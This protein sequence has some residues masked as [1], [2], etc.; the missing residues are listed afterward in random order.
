MKVRC[1][2][3]DFYNNYLTEGKVYEGEL[4]FDERN[5]ENRW[6][7]K[8]LSM[9]AFKEYRF[10]EVKENETMKELTLQEVYTYPEGAKFEMGFDS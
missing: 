8:G 6:F 2:D 5:G 7:I 1:I 3:S 4:R 10:E 9:F